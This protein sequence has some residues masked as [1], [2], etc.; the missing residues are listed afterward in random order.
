MLVL[1]TSN[2]FYKGKMKIGAY[3]GESVESA[4][5]R[6]RKYLIEQGFAL[7]Y[8]EP[9]NK[10]ISRSSDDCIVALMDQ[11]YIDYGEESWKQRALNYLHNGLNTFGDETRNAFDGVLNWLN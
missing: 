6:V 8:A 4:K 11:W 5:P 2:R 10:V 9:E 3:A 7:P 1:I